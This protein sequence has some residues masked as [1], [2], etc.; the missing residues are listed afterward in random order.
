MHFN[1]SS[2]SAPPVIE[3]AM[4]QE[5]FA[6]VDG[7]RMRYLAGGE[8]MPLVLIHGLLGYSFSWRFNLEVLARHARVYAIDLPGSG[9][10]CR[11][12]AL[13]G[14]LASLAQ[15]VLAF[16]QAVGAKSAVL[17]GS[18][19]GGGAALLAAAMA[20]EW[21]IS[22]EAMILASPVNPWSK[23]GI[24]LTSILGSSLGALIFRSMAWSLAPLHGRILMRMYGDPRR[25]APGTVSG[26][27]QPLK[28]PGTLDA[29]LRRIRNWKS[30]LAKIEE[31]LPQVSDIPI[32]LL[33]G[34]RDGAVYLS[35]AQQLMERLHHVELQV[36]PTAGHLPYEELPE[37]FN[38]LA[39]EF[40]AKIQ[41]SREKRQ[42]CL[43]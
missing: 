34:D 40:L 38:Q 24:P 41:G 39:I 42:T 35:S 6:D 37:Q 9:F 4:I 17:L 12:P 43:Q 8:G 33:W 14:D 27:N 20:K 15:Y 7:C 21:N 10:S 23:Q 22:I 2:A 11:N 19:H 25:I 28:I 30:D 16:M 18:S 31:A 3:L 26:Y 36:I 29:L 32:L 1:S 13:T 5:C